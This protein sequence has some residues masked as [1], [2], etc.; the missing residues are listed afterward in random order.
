MTAIEP[1]PANQTPEGI[2]SES[3]TGAV[4]SLLGDPAAVVLGWSGRSIYDP[5]NL[6]TLGVY[7]VAGRARAGSVVSGTGGEWSVIL[8]ITQSPDGLPDEKVGAA[9]E[10]LA[11]RSGL[12]DTLTGVRAPRCYGITPHRDGYVNVWLEDLGD[13]SKDGWQMAD[14][15]TA[16]RDLGR[17]AAPYLTG[18]P[19]P[20]YTWLETAGARAWVARQE[21]NYTSLS[22]IRDHA[23]VRRA[24]PD[25][26]LSRQLAVFQERHTFLD[27]LDRLPRTFCHRDS[28]P[29]NLSVRHHPGAASET[30]AFDWAQAGIGPLGRDL[31]SL[32]PAGAHS[33][34][35]DPH[36]LHEV[37]LVAF[38][39]YVE[40]L[41]ELGWTGDERLARFGYCA[42][43]VMHY[44]IMQIG[45][46]LV[47]DALRGQL[48]RSFG[49]PIE[50]LIDVF[51]EEQRYLMDLAREAR[52]L[53]QFVTA[54]A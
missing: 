34:D 30:V 53:L 23:L 5:V 38:R 16:A 42:S 14:Y 54:S 27:A 43:A 8:K 48:E 20:T 32:V 4:R 19:L 51:V 24:T 17:L 40:G 36:R 33:G 35:V 25:D 7:R 37:D 44:G 26:L 6:V 31:A 21:P 45:P 46:R 28:I 15:V 47:D 10:I 12:L 18:R 1:A 41:R 11:Y 3:L 9:R 29:R 49:L 13:R 2:D 52:S 39:A 50:Q 22:E